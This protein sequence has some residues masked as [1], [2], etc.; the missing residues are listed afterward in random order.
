MTNQE[1]IDLASEVDEEVLRD[2]FE[3]GLELLHVGGTG[4]L[5]LRL[6]ISFTM[7]MVIC[8]ECDKDI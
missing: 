5:L 6:P 7:K 8:C 3:E 2:S 1:E 4:R